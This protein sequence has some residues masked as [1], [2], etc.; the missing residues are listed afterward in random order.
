M[1]PYLGELLT[2]GTRSKLMILIGYA[3]GFG[4]FVMSV[5]AWTVQNYFR[6]IQLTESHAITPWRLQ[7]IILLFPGV[8]GAVLYYFLP[9]SPKFLVSIGESGK[10]LDVLR[11]IHQ[12]NSG[13][14]A[15][16]PI[17]SLEEDAATGHIKCQKMRV[18]S[19][20][21]YF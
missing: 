10:A 3:L 14:T 2:D 8:I 19:I 20:Y 15:T 21:W 13:W 16:F 11:R 5:V 4:M 1:Y 7:M 9:E 18:S 6:T 17:D 12:S